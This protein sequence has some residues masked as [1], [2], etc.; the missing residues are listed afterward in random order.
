MQECSM[1]LEQINTR[2]RNFPDSSGF[3]SCS[4]LTSMSA[5]SACATGDAVQLGMQAG[6]NMISVTKRILI[7]ATLLALVVILVPAAAKAQCVVVR[8]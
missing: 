2:R 3:K 6:G 7:G 1:M 8:V 5:K 4:P